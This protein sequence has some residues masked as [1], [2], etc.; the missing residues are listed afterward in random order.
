MKLSLSAL[1]LG[2]LLLGLT[3]TN[4]WGQTGAGSCDGKA[5]IRAVGS[6]QAATRAVAAMTASSDA[7][8]AG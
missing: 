4:A 5:P 2:I 7:G 8:M 6:R 3:P 1:L